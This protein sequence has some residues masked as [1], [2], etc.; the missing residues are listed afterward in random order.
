MCSLDLRLRLPAL[1]VAAFLF[2]T[3]R[4]ASAEASDLSAITLPSEASHGEIASYLQR[5]MKASPDPEKK[6]EKSKSKE[7]GAKPKEDES[8]PEENETKTQEGAASTPE[9]QVE[10]IARV[11]PDNVVFVFEAMKKST[12][13]RFYHCAEEAL[14]LLANDS[15]KKEF[16]SAMLFLP[17]LI[18]V[19]A[20]KGWAAEAKPVLLHELTLAAAA[21]T[22]LPDKWLC[23][24]ALLKNPEVNARVS[25]YMASLAQE[26]PFYLPEMMVELEEA[27]FAELPNSVVKLGW[28][29]AE[30]VYARQNSK[31]VIKAFHQRMAYAVAGQGNVDALKA[32]ADG[33]A[34]DLPNDMILWDKKLR[35]ERLRQLTGTQTEAAQFSSWVE[36]RQKSLVFDPA[37]KIYSEASTKKD[38]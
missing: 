38:G 27:G 16:L 33:L 11:G 22:S 12:S 8:R 35:L 1:A 17:S 21:K 25:N 20:E 2:L 3:V 31:P 23:Q 10:M 29:I 9:P 28:K 30:E 32:L 19:V 13:L 26:N 14:K 15:N 37:K 36:T 18:S 5:I 34:L 7:K 24:I 6:E 4:A